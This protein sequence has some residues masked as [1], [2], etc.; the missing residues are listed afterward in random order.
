MMR[1]STAVEII[2]LAYA[3]SFYYVPSVLCKKE[4]MRD[5]ITSTTVEDNTNDERI[6][7]E[8]SSLSSSSNND[9]SY[10]RNYV[11]VIEPENFCNFFTKWGNHC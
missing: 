9:Y 10:R 3:A 2:T 7:S 8:L 1:L 5:A 6:L 11:A 4:S